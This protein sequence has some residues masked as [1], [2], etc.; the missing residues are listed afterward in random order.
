MKAHVLLAIYRHVMLRMRSIRFDKSQ[1]LARWLVRCTDT[2]GTLVP[3]ATEEVIH[4]KSLE[5]GADAWL[6][7]FPRFR[8]FRP[9]PCVVKVVV[10]F[11]TLR[12]SNTREQETTSAR[13]EW[14]PPE[15]F[16]LSLPSSSS[17]SSAPPLFSL[18]FIS[19]VPTPDLFLYS[20]FQQWKPFALNRTS[21]SFTS[22]HQPPINHRNIL[23]EL[24][25]FADSPVRIF[26]S[27]KNPSFILLLP[28][29]IPFELLPLVPIKGPMK[30]APEPLDRR[31]MEV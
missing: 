4:E 29:C 17:P 20:L 26:P 24:P 10:F 15:S 25:T 18:L 22:L 3:H 19:S 2:D 28:D 31:R 12:Y 23:H 7:S 5:S 11:T 6:L 16:L 27:V 14:D 30:R 21:I 9:T 1:R 8:D 13:F